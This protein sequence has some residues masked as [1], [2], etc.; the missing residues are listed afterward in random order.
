M[1]N[2]LPSQGMI[3]AV[4]ETIAACHEMQIEC[5]AS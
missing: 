1:E 5:F 2:F 4:L 3:E